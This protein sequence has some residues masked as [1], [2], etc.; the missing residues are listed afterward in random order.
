MRQRKRECP[1]KINEKM[2]V[3]TAELQS[4]MCAGRKTAV[5]IG[6][7]AGAKVSIGR[8]VLWNVEKV[9]RYIDAISE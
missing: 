5:E 8:R 9:Q 7:A 1:V 2:L 3:D 4:L 6:M